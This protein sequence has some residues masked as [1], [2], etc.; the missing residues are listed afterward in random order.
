MT[1]VTMT[2]DERAARGKAA[3]ERAPRSSHSG[4]EPQS[5]RR[6][7]DALLEQE[8][9]RVPEL[10]PVRHGRMLASPFAFFRGGAAIMAADLAGTP[11]SGLRVQLCGDAH[12]LNFGG[13][14]S[15]ER[16][17]V[18]DLNDFDES[19]PGPWEWDVKRLAA[20]VA[21][22]GR[23]LGM[24]ARSRHAVVEGT[25]RAYRE[26][27]RAFAAMSNLQV[28]YSRMNVA[29]IL[30]TAGDRA[31]ARERKAFRR[32][33][34]EAQS[35][36]HVR[37]L[38]KLTEHANGSLRIVSRPPLIVPIEDLLGAAEGEVVEER[39][40]SRLRAYRRGLNS[41]RRH[42][43]DQ[44]RYVHM[45]RKV[46]GVGSVG[47]RA[48]VVLLA[49]RDGGDPLFLQIKEA[50]PSVLE[51][52]T[53][54]SG[55]RNQGQRV[56]EG[57]RLLQAT[58]DIFLGWLRSPGVDDQQ[59]RDFYVRQLWDW[60]VSADV[61]R[62][63]PSRMAIYGEVCGWTLARAH[64]RSGDRVAIAA[65]LGAGSTFDRALADFAEAYAEQNARDHAELVDA[66]REG[67]IAAETGV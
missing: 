61:G 12:L 4:W 3:R 36:D 24:T 21:V 47:T 54:A 20:S 2:V 31:G 37:A 66:V 30:A 40:R 15:P 27:M 33:I 43:L 44:Y 67:R 56:V 7:L 59:E 17:L 28:W 53:G 5:G 55:V 32:R 49:G 65:Y 16:E 26:A 13:F 63:S 9:D 6:P 45:A 14:A 41:D 42:L 39:M 52:Y 11:D 35:K 19:A 38:D 48:W 22:A 60:K 46:V 51:P 29:R 18:F 10:V 57:Q 23:D 62:M 1:S 64:A 8:D 58:S 25:V 50:G 34:T